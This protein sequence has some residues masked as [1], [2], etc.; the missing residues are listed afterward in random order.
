MINKIFNYIKNSKQIDQ[1]VTMLAVITKNG[2]V[3]SIGHNN[4]NR[5]SFNFKQK[6]GYSDLS[7]IHAE[8]DSIRKCFKSQLKGATITVIGINSRSNNQVMSRPCNACLNAIKEVGIKRIIYFDKAG[9]K[10]IEKIK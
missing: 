5:L 6:N 4:K 9:K 10:Y 7:G 1:R 8:V 3:L 2:R